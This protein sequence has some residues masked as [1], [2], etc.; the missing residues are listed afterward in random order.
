MSFSS[1]MFGQN[2][3]GNI[4][5]TIETASMAS[6][7]QEDNVHGCTGKGEEMDGTDRPA[8]SVNQLIDQTVKYG[9]VH[10]ALDTGAISS[11]DLLEYLLVADVTTRTKIS[12]TVVCYFDK[13]QYLKNGQRFIAARPEPIYVAIYKVICAVSN[14]ELLDVV[15]S[16]AEEVIKTVT[17]SSDIVSE[18]VDFCSGDNKDVAAATRQLSV[19]PKYLAS[20]VRQDHMHGIQYLGQTGYLPDNFND[21]LKARCVYLYTKVPL[22]WDKVAR[23]AYQ[24][25]ITLS[26]GL[27]GN[28]MPLKTLKQWVRIMPEVFD[29]ELL[30]VDPLTRQFNQLK[31]VVQ[32]YM[33]GWDFRNGMLESDQITALFQMVKS[34][35]VEKYCATVVD[36]NSVSLGHDI[37][38]TFTN[39]T[40]VRSQVNEENLVTN[41]PRSYSSLDIYKYVD[42]DKY[43]LFTR[44]E[45]S[46]LIANSQ[47]VWTNDKMPEETIH[48]MASRYWLAAKAQLPPPRCLIDQWEKLST[49]DLFERDGKGIRG[50]GNSSATV[51]DVTNSVI[52][53]IDS[54]MGYGDG[55]GDG[56]GNG[57]MVGSSNRE[58]RS[59]GSGG[60][61]GS[62]GGG[63]GPVMTSLDR[64]AIEQIFADD[65]NQYF[66]VDRL[67]DL[68]GTLMNERQLLLQP[69]YG[70]SRDDSDQ[71]D[72]FGMTSSFTVA[73]DVD[74]TSSNSSNS[75]DGDG[76]DRDDH[77]YGI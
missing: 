65:V 48:D 13:L 27:N 45:W 66:S 47:N 29:R 34:I 50:S 8:D 75:S 14:I 70:D 59:S 49:G 46:Y 2:D 23:P 54:D 11:R 63:G 61:G 44:D 43:Y 4:S 10:L 19:M 33:L 38:S 24:K 17:L 28:K 64:D 77:Q 1:Y 15:V 69:R 30:N 67:T 21:L 41:D 51:T 22:Y 6:P 7:Y 12:Y 74:G 55:N 3:N 18:A 68:F 20:M 36:K 39:T 71:S 58:G 57:R 52:S 16:D 26:S 62:G 42:G 40:A 37:L 35:G 72:I 5:Q 9:S 76:D 25:Y 73:L 31:P 53:G 60:S 32:M 56:D